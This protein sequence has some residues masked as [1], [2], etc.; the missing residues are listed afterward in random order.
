MV[1]TGLNTASF[2]DPG[3]LAQNKFLPSEACQAQAEPSAL[4]ETKTSPWALNSMLLILPACVICFTGTGRRLI[5][6]RRISS[7]SF[8]GMFCHE[9]MAANV[10]VKSSPV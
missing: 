10:L 2:I 8:E 7:A 1:A 9:S 5:F 4:A 6:F 3:L